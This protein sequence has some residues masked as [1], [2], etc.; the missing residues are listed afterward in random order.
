MHIGLGIGLLAPT[1][2]GGGGIPPVG[3]ADVSTLVQATNATTSQ[4]TS[5]VPAGSRGTR[6]YVTI[7]TPYSPGATLAVGN[8]GNAS[9]LLAAG[10]IDPTVANAVYDIPVPQAWT[11]GALPLLVTIGGAPAAGAA[12]VLYV[13]SVPQT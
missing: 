6:L 1:G 8:S 7:T 12:D 4:S 13:S 2:A 10:A 3:G 11:G 9:L 5:S